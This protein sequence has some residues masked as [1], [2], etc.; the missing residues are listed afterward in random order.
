LQKSKNSGFLR[1][2]SIRA[3][4][5]KNDKYLIIIFLCFFSPDRKR[6]KKPPFRTFAITS[7]GDCLKYL[8]TP[9]HIVPTTDPTNAVNLKKFLQSFEADRK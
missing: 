7:D 2:F 9:G 6:S 8:N 4:K 5:H 3:K 1:D